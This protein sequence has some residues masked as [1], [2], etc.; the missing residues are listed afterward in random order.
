MMLLT[1][2]LLTAL[3]SGASGAVFSVADYGAKGGGLAAD[4]A[5]NT[6]AFERAFADAAAAPPPTTVHVPAGV[7]FSGPIQYSASRQTLQLAQGARVV[8]VRP[9]ARPHY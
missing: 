7:Y 2:V 1:P 6:K 9:A 3:L 8:A 4:H 5:A